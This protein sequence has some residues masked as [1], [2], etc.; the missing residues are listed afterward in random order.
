MDRV[1]EATAGSHYQ[2]LI[3]HAKGMMEEQDGGEGEQAM[4]SIQFLVGSGAL[5]PAPVAEA[6]LERLRS[7]PSASLKRVHPLTLLEFLERHQRRWVLDASLVRA[8][9]LLLVQ[10]RFGPW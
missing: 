4:G 10:D 8:V 5:L 1:T 6:I 3:S 7:L 2:Q 9:R